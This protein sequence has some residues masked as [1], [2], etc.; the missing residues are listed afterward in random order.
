MRSFLKSLLLRFPFLLQ[1]ARTLLKYP[2]VSY[3][4]NRPLG[5]LRTRRTFTRG[6][7]AQDEA[8]VERLVA[9]YRSRSEA[10]TGQWS[11]IFLDR[12]KDIHDSFARD[13]RARIR[14]IL[15]NPVSSDLMYGFDSTARSLREG[16]LRLEDRLAPKWTL[17]ALV[18]F[19]EAIGARPVEYP[20][21]YYAGRIPSI[22]V[23]TVLAQIERALGIELSFPN[24]YPAELGLPSTR[25]V[26]SYRAP[27]A[28][29]Q[30]WRIAQLL[31]ESR[32]RSVVEIGGGLGRT[33]YYASLFG[34]TDYTIVDIPVSSLA[35]G[36]F[37]GRTLGPDRIS[38]A[39]E[40]MGP[41]NVKLVPPSAFLGSD[42]R[43]ALVVNVDSL[44]ELGRPVAEQYCAAIQRQAAA[45][46]SINHEANE[47]TVGQLL[48]AHRAYRLPY[49]LRRGYVEELYRF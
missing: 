35:Q 15:R 11:D 38:L 17:D 28:L 1:W 29:Y 46:L 47:F 14:E 7:Q 16:G 49:W 34:I 4:F 23:E 20:E 10:P 27:Q 3:C 26:I 48:P 2:Y 39:G 8:L 33:A 44:T 12:H 24:P 42:Q 18:S 40:P 45:F 5:S 13:D 19:A 22:E 36:Y 6:E 41:S 32:T 37:L 43:Y 25:G 21:N 30:A 9:S 31:A